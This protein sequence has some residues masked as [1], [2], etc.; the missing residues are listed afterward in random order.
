MG[1]HSDLS[2]HVR[3]YHP[4]ME[5]YLRADGRVLGKGGL[6]FFSKPLHEL[7]IVLPEMVSAECKCRTTSGDW[8]FFAKNGDSILQRFPQSPVGRIDISIS[9]DSGQIHEFTLFIS[10]VPGFSPEPIEDAVLEIQQ[11]LQTSSAYPDLWPGY[12]RERAS[13]DLECR[14]ADGFLEYSL[15]IDLVEHQQSDRAKNR[16]ESALGLL[17]PFRRPMAHTVCCLLGIKMNCFG[18]LENSKHGSFFASLHTFVSEYTPPCS[19]HAVLN[20]APSGIFADR[21]TS[22]FILCVQYYHLSMPEMMRDQL[23]ELDSHPLARQANQKVKLDLL[24]A[25]LHRWY[26]EREL[27]IKCYRQLVDHHQFCHEA[28]EFIQGNS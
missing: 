11:E 28:T 22:N 8:S 25:R 19:E 20:E 2:K 1:K 5:I 3:L 17:A 27:A 24:W 16:L 23:R 26:G 18:P 6:S 4:T 15:G 21:F 7:Y 10:E 13:N 9:I 14:Y 12:I